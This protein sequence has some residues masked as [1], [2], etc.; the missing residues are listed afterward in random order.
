MHATGLDGAL[1]SSKV[2]SDLDCSHL[3]LEFPLPSVHHV[4]WAHP[5]T[6]HCLPSVSCLER[7]A[8]VAGRGGSGFLLL[9]QLYI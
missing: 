2:A 9:R 3:A 1:H 5:Y 4:A 6:S 7:F 8:A